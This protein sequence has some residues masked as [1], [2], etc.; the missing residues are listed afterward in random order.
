MEFIALALI[1]V[2]SVIHALAHYRR[3]SFEQ[4]LHNNQATGLRQT[5]ASAVA[6]NVGS[7]TIVGIF[8]FGVRGD[9]VAIYISVCYA[10]GLVFTALL[11]GLVYRRS[12]EENA[13]SLIDFLAA[14]YGE[15]TRKIVWLA[16]GSIFFLAMAAQ[17]LALGNILAQTTS[18]PLEGAILYAYAIV[19]IYLLSGGYYS[20]TRTD[21]VQ[22]LFIFVTAVLVLFYLDWDAV[23]AVPSRLYTP[24]NYSPVFVLGILIFL[25]PSAPISIDNW[26]RV[27]AS[28]DARVAR[29]GF[30]IAS[31]LCLVVYLSFS[32]LGLTAPPGTDE[33]VGLMREIFPAMLSVFGILAL[34]MAVVS[35]MDSTILPL[36]A[37]ICRNTRG[38]RL[39]AMRFTVFAIMSGIALTAYVLGDV[40]TGLIGALSSMVALFP[41]VFTALL[42]QRPS[43][44]ALNISLPAAILSSIAF[45]MVDEEHAFLVGIGVSFV[46]FYGI[47]FWDLRRRDVKRWTP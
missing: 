44:L 25:A 21:Q 31:A 40:V 9:A 2:Y 11:A 45:L 27:I 36:A 15:E 14:W 8:A 20:V 23:L 5:C 16:A 22:F 1:L 42:K 6:G 13:D 29:N 34:V 28:R 39:R 46:L 33:P 37:P 19:T 4:F 17:L 12:R 30:L 10:L 26:H 47:R 18:I 41:V 3:V 32:L 35:T 24:V 43:A 38:D 7:G